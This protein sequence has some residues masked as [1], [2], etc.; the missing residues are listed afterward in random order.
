MAGCGQAPPEAASPESW[1]PPPAPAT[2]VWPDPPARAR[3]RFLTNII[4]PEDIRFRKSWTRRAVEWLAGPEQSR[5]IRPYGITA[6]DGVALV[7]TDLGS[8]SVHVFDF[9][10]QRYR[11]LTLEGKGGFRSPTG[12]ALDKRGRLYV[13]DSSLAVIFV[14][15]MEGKLVRTIGT[16]GDFI[17]PTGLA[18]NPQQE[19]LYVVDSKGHQVVVYDPEGQRRYSF[20]TRGKKPGEFNFPTHIFVAENEEV[21]VTDSMNFRVQ[22]FGPKGTFRFALGNVGD[23]AGDLSKPK[24]VAVDSEGHVYV[25]DAMF[26]NVQILSREGTPLLAFGSFG[27][28]HGQF[29]LPAGLWIDG[30]DRIYVADSF[31]QRVQVF[32]Y[33]R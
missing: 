17:R 28:D 20:G 5:F 7:V 26:D 13:A 8:S 15:T 21:Y 24:G 12:V 30:R 19:L 3:V 2:L 6:K 1:T 29:W 25:V 9:R 22:A 11:N 16:E 4:S 14:L 23:S 33:V 27:Q 10:R 32:Q 31:N 18:L